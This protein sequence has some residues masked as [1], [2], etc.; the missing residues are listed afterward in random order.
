MAKPVKKIKSVQNI[1]PMQNIAIF[2]LDETLTKK[3]TWGRFV[4]S[5]IRGEPL[6]YIPFAL[7]TLF[8]QV[9]YML[10]IGPREHVKEAMMRRTLSGRSRVKLEA[11]A[12]KFALFEAYDG[13]RPQAKAVIEKHRKAGDRIIIASAAVDLI[14]DPIAKHLNITETVCTKMAYTDDG[15]LAGKLGGPN[16]YGPGKLTMVKEYLAKETSFDRDNVHI[17]MYSDS[18]SDLD[19][20]RWADVGIAV[21]PSPRLAKLVSEYGFEVQIW[22]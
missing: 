11:M 2:D 5:S 3:G 6:K 18:R 4:V 20:L 15:V 10:G 7:Q 9:L 14:V 13:M 17:I 16:C 8:S 1:K 19:I 21:H 12:E 22:D